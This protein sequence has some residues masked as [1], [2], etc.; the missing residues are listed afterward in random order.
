[1]LL[2]PLNSEFPPCPPYLREKPLQGARPFV[3]SCEKLQG[4]SRLEW[5]HAKSTKACKLEFSSRR[6]ELPIPPWRFILRPQELGS[7]VRE[8]VSRSQEIY[9]QVQEMPSQLQEVVSQVHEV[10]CSTWDQE[11]QRQDIPSDFR[12]T[13]GRFFRR[14]LSIA[15]G[16]SRS[17]PSAHASGFSKAY[18]D[19]EQRGEVVHGRS[20]SPKDHD[21]GPA[22]L[23]GR[24]GIPS[25]SPRT[26]WHRVWR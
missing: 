17:C 14:L 23:S 22:T 1:M 16:I 18:H 3:T 12:K 25:V 4:S 13:L 7:P 10:F 9:F 26:A 5:T 15:L 8:V 24:G 21:Q 2:C 19:L 11:S 6:R 20:D